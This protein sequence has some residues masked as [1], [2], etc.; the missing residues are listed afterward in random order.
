MNIV[1]C[2]VPVDYATLARSVA[3]KACEPKPDPDFDDCV[4]EDIVG[5]DGREVV[6]CIRYFT[7]GSIQCEMRGDL[8]RRNDAS[9]TLACA[10]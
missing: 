9:H 1:Q 7:D 2:M 5:E 3:L 8:I 10:H 6:G 4:I